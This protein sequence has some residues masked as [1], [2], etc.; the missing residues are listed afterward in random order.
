MSLMLAPSLTRNRNGARAA[1]S[2]IDSLRGVARNSRA[3]G[4]SSPSIP[5]VTNFEA[6]VVGLVQGL[7]EFLP[8]S[9]TAHL[10]FAQKMMG[11]DAATVRW[12]EVA[13][14]LGTIGAVVLYYR[15]DLAAYTRDAIRGGPG[16]KLALLVVAATAPL[17]LVVLARKLFPG[18]REWRDDA[19]FAAFALLGVGVFLLAT[20]FAKRRENPEA[21]WFDA[22]WMGLGQCVSA[23]VTGWSRSGSTIGF[24]L[25]RGLDAA[26]A[27]R[28]S[29][30]MSIPAVVGGS[31]FEIKDMTKADAPVAS[32]G[33]AALAIA[34]VVAFVSGL[35]AI[36]VLLTFVGRGRLYWF[37]PYCLAAGAAALLWIV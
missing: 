25:F 16:R 7:T 11:A 30:L 15:R 33:A 4:R 1:I 22:V 21:G 3:A 12:I 31:L 2:T 13:T 17:V 6:A 18:I 27:A 9:S 35:A 20:K 19:R 28:F 26:W 23:I 37:G 34:V 32:P 24:G 14:H 36:H 29:F 8:V 5:R 10:L